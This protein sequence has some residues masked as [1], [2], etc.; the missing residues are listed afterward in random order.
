MSMKNS[1]DTIGNRSRDLPVCSAVPQPLRHCVPRQSGKL[2]RKL[3]PYSSY[4]YLDICFSNSCSYKVVSLSYAP[5]NATWLRGTSVSVVGGCYAIVLEM[6]GH[7]V[8]FWS[9]DAFLDSISA[10]VP[11]IVVVSRICLCFHHSC[12]NSTSWRHTYMYV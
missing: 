10:H 5:N 6:Y 3:S 12:F 7:R 4:V 2:F 11:N 1:N 9:K 8:W